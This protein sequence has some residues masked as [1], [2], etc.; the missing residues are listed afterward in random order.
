MGRVHC[1][2]WLGWRVGIGVTA[3]ITLV[4]SGQA[5]ASPTPPPWTSGHLPTCNSFTVDT[6]RDPAL[7]TYTDRTLPKILSFLPRTYIVDNHMTRVRL[8][9]THATDSCSGI[10]GATMSVR[11]DQAHGPRQYGSVTLGIYAG[12]PWDAWLGITVPAS[13]KDVGMLT[14]RGIEVLDR[15]ATVALDPFNR[16]SSSTPSTLHPSTAQAFAYNGVTFK[17]LR[18]TTMSINVRDRSVAVG[19]S[20]LVSGKLVVANGTT[21]VPVVGQRVWL[22]RRYSAAQ[23]WRSVRS[24]LT[25]TAGTVSIRHRPLRKVYYRLMYAGATTDY[26]ASS[27]SRVASMRVS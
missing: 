22:Q 10:A 27:H 25:S 15:Y 8:G 24:A 9:I 2:S 5:N 18:R 23:A 3:V 11:I 26:N 1:H 6:T 21:W 4:L 19:G 13:A 7:I 20:T 16:Y 17:L 12:T 14:V